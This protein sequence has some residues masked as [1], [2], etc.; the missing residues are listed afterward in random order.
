MNTVVSSIMSGV[1]QYLPVPARLFRRGKRIACPGGGGGPIDVIGAEVSENAA[2][3]SAFH[4]AQG[5][6]V[7]V[8]GV[9]AFPVVR[10]GG[11]VVSES[12]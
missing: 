12:Q 10:L 1:M 7:R 11:A 3:D 9:A 8:A 4:A 5:P 2:G 6:R